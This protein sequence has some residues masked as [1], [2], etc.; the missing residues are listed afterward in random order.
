MCTYRKQPTLVLPLSMTEGLLGTHLRER[1]CCCACSPNLHTTICRTLS[2]AQ[3]SSTAPMVGALW[4][5]T[6]LPCVQGRAVPRPSSALIQSVSYRLFKQSA[7]GA[8]VVMPHELVRQCF[9]VLR[10]EGCL[11]DPQSQETKRQIP[12]TPLPLLFYYLEKVW[13]VWIRT[14]L[15][16]SK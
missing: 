3:P 2:V 11:C 1:S 9:G 8:K 7:L 16:C 15:Q 5:D 10:H 12:V 4:G 14:L 13:R 6:S